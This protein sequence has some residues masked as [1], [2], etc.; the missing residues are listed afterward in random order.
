MPTRWAVGHTH[1]R[2]RGF[3][4]TGPLVAY[5]QHLACSHR[6][7]EITQSVFIQQPISYQNIHAE[8][9]A[10]SGLSRLWGGIKRSALMENG[11]TCKVKAQ[12]RTTIRSLCAG[13]TLTSVR[14]G[15]K[16]GTYKPRVTQKCRQ[17]HGDLLSTGTFIACKHLSALP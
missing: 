10:L 13:I 15:L 3:S 4:H 12:G 2:H 5:K 7:S 1:S 8:R 16:L 6:F 11:N 14:D 17:R 9:T